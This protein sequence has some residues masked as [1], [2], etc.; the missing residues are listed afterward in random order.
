MTIDRS[1]KSMMDKAMNYA[2][3]YDFVKDKIF[4]KAK[5]QVMKMSG[6]LYPA[7]LKVF[8]LITYAV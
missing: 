5:Q 8:D 4:G 6:G 1:K 7:P 3:K 2:L